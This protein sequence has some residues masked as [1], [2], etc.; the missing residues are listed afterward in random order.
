MANTFS[1]I[2]IHTVFA[3]KHRERLLDASWQPTL[4]K[5]MAG[6]LNQI[7]CKSLAV[8][9][10]YDH[11]HALFGLPPSKSVADVME[12]LKSSSSKW[13]NEQGLCKGQFRWQAGYGAFS[14]SQ[15]QRPVVIQYIMQQHEHHARRSFRQE[16]LELLNRHEID[17]DSRYMFEFFE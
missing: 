9:G 6:I 10:W 8:N 3:V 12:V 4:F 15:S 1:Q 17:W 5:Y 11:A 16:Y 7:G 13:V 14:V 2:T